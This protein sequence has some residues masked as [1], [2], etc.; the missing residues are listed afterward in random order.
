MQD[1]LGVGS[2]GGWESAWLMG[3]QDKG[4]AWCGR[5]RFVCFLGEK[6]EH[7]VIILV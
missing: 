3:I 6:E 1:C 7:Y 5:E 4:E 2:F